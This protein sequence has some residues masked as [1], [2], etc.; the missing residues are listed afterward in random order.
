[1]S[2][3][4]RFFSAK[5]PAA[6]QSVIDRVSAACEDNRQA[7]I[8][9]R[10]AIDRNPLTRALTPPEKAVQIHRIAHPGRRGV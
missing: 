2:F 10:R 5:V 9:L 7:T 3:L 8:E 1:M 6:T 4:R